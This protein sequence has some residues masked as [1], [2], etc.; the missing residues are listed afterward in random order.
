M[1]IR[2]K[3][4]KFSRGDTFS[5]IVTFNG[6]VDTCTFHDVT[7]PSNTED[8]IKERFLED[9]YN[10]MLKQIEDDEYSDLYETGGAYG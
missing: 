2:N 6:A 8:E 10:A 7:I 1:N 3:T 4:I 9:A 5:C